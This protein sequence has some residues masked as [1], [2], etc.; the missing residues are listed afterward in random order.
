[1]NSSGASPISLDTNWPSWDNSYD[2]DGAKARS[3]PHGYYLSDLSEKILEQVS[4]QETTYY[5]SDIPLNDKVKDLLTRKPEMVAF[6]DVYHKAVAKLDSLNVKYEKNIEVS[7]DP[8]D[9]DREDLIIVFE[10]EGKSYDEIL[11]LWDEVAKEAFSEIC[12]KDPEIAGK[13][14][15]IFRRKV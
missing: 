8:D 15:I 11:S 5:F 6:T 4:S 10:I 3:F 12:E 9:P 7:R 14:E 1:M 13:I 2:Y